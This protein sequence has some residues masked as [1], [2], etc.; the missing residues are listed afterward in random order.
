MHRPFLITASLLAALSIA[1]GAFGAHALKKSIGVTEL[2]IFETGVRY[3]M[4]HAMALLAVAI[5]YKDFKQQLLIWAGRAFIAGTLLF[6]GSLYSLSLS[7]DHK[8]IGV[9]TP[10]GGLL[11]IAGWLLMILAFCKRIKV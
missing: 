8:W 1:L 9:I 5:L 6:S 2:N 11:F 7:P 4:Y 10:F 3:Q